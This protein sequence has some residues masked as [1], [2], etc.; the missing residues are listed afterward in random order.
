[1]KSLDYQLYSTNTCLLDAN[2]NHFYHCADT[3]SIYYNN[4]KP[5]II[6]SQQVSMTKITL[7]LGH[8]HKLLVPN[9]NFKSYTKVQTSATN[10]NT[11]DNDIRTMLA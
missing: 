6:I 1:M 5:V 8:V 11:V 2:V 4:F 10:L 9:Y 7:F 3:L